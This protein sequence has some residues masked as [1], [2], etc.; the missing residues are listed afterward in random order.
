MAAIPIAELKGQCHDQDYRSHHLPRVSTI[1]LLAK[2]RDES[3][4][5]LQNPVVLLWVLK[6]EASSA[7]AAIF[8]EGL[9]EN[10]VNSSPLVEF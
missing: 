5:H 7:S 9:N 3:S 10:L 8:G 4:K 6:F 2:I 1:E